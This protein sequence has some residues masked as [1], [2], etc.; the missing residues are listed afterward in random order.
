MFGVLVDYAHNE[1]VAYIGMFLIL[2]AFVLE[3]RGVL[4]SKEMPYLLLMALGSGLLAVRAFLI[5]EWAFLILE[6]VWFAAALLG[7]WS[8]MVSVKSR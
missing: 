8:L 3:T 5:E 7:V 4:Q 6:V 1:L 2:S